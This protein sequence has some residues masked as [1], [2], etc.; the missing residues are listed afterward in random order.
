[1]IITIICCVAQVLYQWFVC[2]RKRV[3]GLFVWDEPLC[4]GMYD[5]L[6]T[7]RERKGSVICIQSLKEYSFLDIALL[8][9]AVYFKVI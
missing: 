1:M 5:E 7:G 2:G 6:K 9:I 3:V 8:C 4:L